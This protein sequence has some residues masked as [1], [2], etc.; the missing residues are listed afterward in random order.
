MS[1]ARVAELRR[2]VAEAETNAGVEA[3]IAA[4]REVIKA[5]DAYAVASSGAVYK[6]LNR[7]RTAID[8]LEDLVGRP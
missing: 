4:G 5:W 2:L 3:V 6:K 8:R 7:V 1:A